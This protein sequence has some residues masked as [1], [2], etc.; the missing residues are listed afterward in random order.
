[1]LGA[2]RQLAG[3][4]PHSL[5][6]RSESVALAEG[7][8]VRGQAN[9]SSHLSW[10]PNSLKWYPGAISRN[11]T[12]SRNC[13]SQAKQITPPRKVHHLADYYPQKEQNQQTAQV[14]IRNPEARV[15][16]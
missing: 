12:L 8:A 5:S 3:L 11:A 13:V 14:D 4:R 1:M 16:P 7:T 2:E 10:G 15:E 6:R 9:A